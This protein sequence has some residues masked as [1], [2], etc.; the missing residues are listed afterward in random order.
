MTME[1][2][3]PRTKP[4]FRPELFPTCN[5]QPCPPLEQTDPESCILRSAAAAYYEINELLD[6]L[7]TANRNSDSSGRLEALKQI[8]QANERRNKL[9]DQFETEGLELRPKLSGWKTVDVGLIETLARDADQ[10]RQQAEYFD[11]VIPIS[12]P[13]DKQPGL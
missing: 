8:K 7:L 3:D 13:K 5:G 4:G 1:N 10:D 6:R 12:S 9:A 11:L 2:E